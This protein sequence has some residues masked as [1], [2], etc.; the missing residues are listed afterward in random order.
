MEYEMEYETFSIN[1]TFYLSAF[2]ILSFINIS[3]YFNIWISGKSFLSFPQ[4]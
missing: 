4:P 1:Q 2:W 3:D